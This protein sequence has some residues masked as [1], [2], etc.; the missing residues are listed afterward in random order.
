MLEN[1]Q[2]QQNT[3][4][5]ESENMPISED[6]EVFPN[7]QPPITEGEMDKSSTKNMLIWGGVV[8]ILSAIVGGYLLYDTGTT[9]EVVETPAPT[10]EETETPKPV[11]PNEPPT[12]LSFF[13]SNYGSVTEVKDGIATANNKNTDHT[14]FYMV[15]NENVPYVIVHPEQKRLVVVSRE[16]AEGQG[17]A[18]AHYTLTLTSVENG[19]L[20]GAEI[21]TTDTPYSPAQLQLLLQSFEF[22]AGGEHLF[23]TYNDGEDFFNLML[24]IPDAL[25]QDT[26]TPTVTNVIAP[27]VNDLV[28]EIDELSNLT[29]R[30]DAKGGDIGVAY[31]NSSRELDATK[32]NIHYITFGDNSSD[33]KVVYEYNDFDEVF[34]SMEFI[35]DKFANPVLEIVMRRNDGGTEKNVYHLNLENDEFELFT[36]RQ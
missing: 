8:I 16:K 29:W 3:E 12:L 7:D 26:N 34:E 17:E 21:F 22:S 4:T 30:L 6:S 15:A 19:D 24:D 11:V 9:E 32:R 35:E 18:R 36:T 13:E 1:E 10:E 23:L 5:Q 33:L 28:H 31:L 25:A 14:K 20:K 2:E 27:F